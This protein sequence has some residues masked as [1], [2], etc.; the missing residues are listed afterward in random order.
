MERDISGDSFGD[1][2]NQVRNHKKIGKV[3]LENKVYLVGEQQ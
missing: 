2:S 1:G 3:V